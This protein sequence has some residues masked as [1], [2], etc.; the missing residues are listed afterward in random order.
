MNIHRIHRVA[1]LTGLTKDVLRVWERRYGLLNPTRG[2]N[3]YRN[4]SDDDVLLLRYLKGELDKGSSIGELAVSGREELLERARA[5]SPP[6]ARL[7]LDTPFARLLDELS[8][9]LEPLDKTG[10]ERR[11][12][13]AVAIV[14]FEEALHGILIPLQQRVG[15]MWHAG[16]ISIAVEHYVSNLVQQKLFSVIN[17]FP[18]TDQGPKVIVG[19]PANEHHELGALAVAY[20]CA[21]R[22][23]RVIYVGRNTPV[24]DLARLCRDIEPALVLLSVTL[25]INGNDLRALVDS[26]IEDVAPLCPIGLGGPGLSSLR[27]RGDMRLTLLED[28]E[29][30]DRALDRFLP[31]RSTVG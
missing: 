27:D 24:K 19:C 10:F 12:N 22:G 9:S 17:Q 14:P 29:A 6:P 26:L 31:A 5:A 18:V 16:K 21:V 28:F 23:Y 8:V 25:S 7:S 4:Y 1:K 11:L 3:R 30:L 13:G 15:E 2:S 20:H